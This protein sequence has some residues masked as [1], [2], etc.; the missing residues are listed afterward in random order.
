MGFQHPDDRLTTSAEWS[1]VAKYLDPTYAS[2]YEAYILKYWF[3]T[4]HSGVPD[5]SVFHAKLPKSLAESVAD[6]A[7][8]QELADQ[9]DPQEDA[10]SDC[11]GC[12]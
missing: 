7:W 2:M 4:L 11:R 5:R 12:A 1:G 8:M 10:G 9:Q 6:A 3:N